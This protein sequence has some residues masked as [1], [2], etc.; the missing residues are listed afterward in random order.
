MK[1][2]A[3]PPWTLRSSGSADAISSVT[4]WK[5]RG[6]ARSVISRWSHI[7]PD[8]L[9]GEPRHAHVDAL[10]AE[11]DAFVLEQRPLARA[12]GERAV[13]AHDPPPGDGGVVALE[14]H[15]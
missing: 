1:R 14:Q 8:T 7:A 13:R 2:C 12:F 3:M 6:R 15:G 10:A 11:R 4:R 5:P 9:R